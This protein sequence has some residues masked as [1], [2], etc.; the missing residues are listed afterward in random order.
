M[1]RT[2]SPDKLRQIVDAALR[3]FVAEGY[4]AARVEEVAERAGVSAGTIYLYATGKE[5]LF[6]LTLRTA[7]GEPLPDVDD[8][9]YGATIGPGM[10]EWMWRRL[11]AVSPFSALRAAAAREA[12]VEPGAE[13]D[14][15]VGELWAWQARYW[16]ALE[17]LE[18]CGREWPELDL[19]YYH[20]FRRELLELGAVWLSRRMDDGHLLAYADPGTAVRVIAETV[21]FF[22]MHRHVRP[23]TGEIREDVARDTVL[24][25]LRRGFVPGAAGP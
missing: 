15:V 25:L 6:E 2:R 14:E 3:V 7:F 11:A 10:I 21:T 13:F 16:P 5:A 17:L 19:L 20:Q 4:R 24:L 22:A 18:R 8:A 1:V 23:H 12:P 9:P